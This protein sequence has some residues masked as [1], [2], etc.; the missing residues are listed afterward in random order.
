MLGE[1]GMVRQGESNI[2]T[3]PSE[4]SIVTSSLLPLLLPFLNPR[5]PSSFPHPQS[6]ARALGIW[7]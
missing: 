3:V 4:V 5:R 2:T 7:H 6:P 1:R